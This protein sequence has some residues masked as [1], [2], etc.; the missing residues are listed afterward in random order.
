LPNV[1]LG[2][3]LQLKAS[4]MRPSDGTIYYVP[5]C[6]WTSSDTR[7]AAAS[8]TGVVTG[9]TAGTVDITADYAGFKSRPY[10]LTVVAFSSITINTRSTTDLNTGS[11]TQLTATID[12]PDGKTEDIT[13]RATWKSSNP[14]VAAFTSPGA[15]TAQNHGT[16]SIQVVWEG[17]SS[18][19]VFLNVVN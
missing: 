13:G 5:T 19:P 6:N 7:I 16:F 15:I 17:I 12:Y 9:L 11:T 8:P 14:Q 2:G 1:M 10:S 18:E 4:C 3:T